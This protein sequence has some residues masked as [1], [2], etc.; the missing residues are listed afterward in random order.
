MLSQSIVHQAS[1]DNRT[2]WLLPNLAPVRWQIAM[3]WNLTECGK[4]EIIEFVE[5][6]DNI[7]LVVV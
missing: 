6:R 3:L 7:H 2:G 4:C 1:N 5:R